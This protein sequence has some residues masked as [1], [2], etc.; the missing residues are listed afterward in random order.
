MLALGGSISFT[1]SGGPGWKMEVLKSQML[2][3]PID[4]SSADFVTVLL[5]HLIDTEWCRSG[6]VSPRLGCGPQSWLSSV[7]RKHSMA[8]MLRRMLWF[9]MSSLDRKVEQPR[10][11]QL[12]SRGSSHGPQL[13]CSSPRQVTHSGGAGTLFPELRPARFLTYWQRLRCCH[14]WPRPGCSHGQ[15]SWPH[16]PSHQCRCHQTL[17]WADQKPSR[18]PRACWL[19]FHPLLECRQKTLC[20]WNQWSC[21]QPNMVGMPVQA[22]EIPWIL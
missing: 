8:D 18:C 16:A 20:I 2:M 4:A 6:A 12:K 7:V 19:A 14:G 15:R 9:G 1:L 10:S 11:S 21:C 17:T 5:V 3:A 22:E 13:Q